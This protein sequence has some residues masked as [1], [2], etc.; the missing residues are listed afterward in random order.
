ME[1]IGHGRCKSRAEVWER[2][3]GTGQGEGYTNGRNINK[4]IV[5]ENARMKPNTAYANLR[6]KLNERELN[7]M[8][9]SQ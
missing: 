6:M 7:K 5:F 2:V 1:P 3:E 8:S 4:G 9:H